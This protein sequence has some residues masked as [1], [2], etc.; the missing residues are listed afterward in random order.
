MTSDEAR[1]VIK[2]NLPV[3]Q[4]AAAERLWEMIAPG[5]TMVGDDG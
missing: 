3:E 2:R 1:E 5:E 4:W